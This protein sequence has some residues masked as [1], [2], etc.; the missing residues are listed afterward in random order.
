MDDEEEIGFDLAA[1]KKMNKAEVEW[2]VEGDLGD[3]V[4]NCNVK[5]NEDRGISIDLVEG[6]RFYTTRVF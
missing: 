5:N 2:A 4:T 6:R 3:F 1:Y